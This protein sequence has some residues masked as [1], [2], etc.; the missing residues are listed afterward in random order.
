VRCGDAH[1]VLDDVALDVVRALESGG[2]HVLLSADEDAATLAGLRFRNGTSVTHLPAN[3]VRL[4]NV[5]IHDAKGQC[6]TRGHAVAT[7]PKCGATLSP[8]V[9]DRSTDLCV[10]LDPM[11]QVEAESIVDEVL[12]RGAG[13]ARD[14]AIG[15]T[16]DRT[17]C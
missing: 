6:P 13:I 17:S 8:V 14:F 5:G 16:G 2:F 15:C 3:L 7:R 11:A 4:R 12:A 9:V 1:A 10:H